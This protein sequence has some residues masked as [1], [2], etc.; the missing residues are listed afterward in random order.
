MTDYLFVDRRKLEI[1]WHG[2]GPDKAPTL[3]F[4][5]EGLGCVAL[6]RDFPEKLA[7]AT[8]CGAFVYSRLG[9]GKSDPCGLPRPIRFMHTEEIG[10]AHV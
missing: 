1:A 10:R 9:Y 8:G 2:P 3:V 4:L 6:W 7:A 5:H